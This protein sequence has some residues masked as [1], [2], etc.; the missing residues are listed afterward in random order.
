M[1][2][3]IKLCGVSIRIMFEVSICLSA[4]KYKSE[5]YSLYRIGC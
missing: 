4:K 5:Y 3:C 1:N 2:I